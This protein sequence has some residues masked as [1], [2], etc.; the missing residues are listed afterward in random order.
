MFST[1]SGFSGAEQCADVARRLA[2]CCVS[3]VSREEDGQQERKKKLPLLFTRAFL[4]NE[5]AGSVLGKDQKGD[6]SI[7]LP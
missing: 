3:R 5:L 2:T 1:F 7:K 6:V 4:R